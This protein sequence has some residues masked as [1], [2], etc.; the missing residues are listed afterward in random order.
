MNYK[1][2]G[3]FY[4]FFDRQGFVEFIKD[5]ENECNGTDEWCSIFGFDLETD[6]EGVP[7]ETIDEY[8]KRAK[9]DPEPESYPCTCYYSCENGCDRFGAMKYLVYDFIEDKILNNT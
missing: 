8:A 9:F 1:Q 2:A 5:R 7:I 3:N 6:D 4:K